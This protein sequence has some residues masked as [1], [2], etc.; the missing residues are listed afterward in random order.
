MPEA[1]TPI[2]SVLIP[3]YNSER[4][5]RAA[6]Q[7]IL[8]QT[9]REFELIAVDDGST[10]RTTPI[11]QEFAGRDPRVRVISRPNTG[12]AG[13]LNDGLAAARG[14]FIARMDADDIAL[15]QRFERQ[16]A[17]MREHPDCVLLGSRVT[18][19]DPYDTPLWDTDQATDHKEIESWLLEARGWALIHPA[20]MMRTDAVRRIGGYRSDYVPIEDMDLFLRLLDT[21]GR[22][23]NL[24]DVLLHYR[25][26]PTSANHTRFEEQEAKRRACVAEAYG[27]RG[28]MMPANWQPHPRSLMPLPDLFHHWGWQAV[29]HQRKDVARRHAV[30]L[31][32][33][34][35]FSMESWKLMYCALRGR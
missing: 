3:A 25:Q 21:G 2:I 24:P 33:L 12:I 26:H 7:S 35:P 8:E 6:V 10:D 18:L 14:E 30:S 11:L 23:A 13:A 4:Y 32:K 20:V 31:L 29:K 5:L 1:S 16:L 17:Y 27:R 28:L 22:L 15:P 9:Y 19:V 34:Q